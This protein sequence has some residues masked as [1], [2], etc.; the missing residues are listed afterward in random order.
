MS[1]EETMVGHL[2]ELRKRLIWTLSFFVAMLIVTFLFVEELKEFFVQDASRLFP[3]LGE[4][5][6]AVLGPGEIVK[7]FFMIA[8]FSAFALTIPFLMYQI[9]A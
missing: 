6:L 9:W 3:E 8:G 5:K 1:Q 7:V 4:I 2:S